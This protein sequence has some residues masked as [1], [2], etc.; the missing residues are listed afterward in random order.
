METIKLEQ[1]IESTDAEVTDRPCDLSVTI[2]GVSIDSRTTKPGDCFFAV[3]GENFDGHDFLGQAISNGACCAVVSK[4]VEGPAVPLLL[5]EDPVMAL[6]RLAKWYRGR[7]AAKVIA[8]TGSTGKTSTRQII[9]H[10]LKESCNCHQPIKNFNNAIGLPLT[11]L[12][13]DRSCEV[14]ITE[15]GT[16]HPGEIEYLTKIAQPDIALITNVAP[17]HIAGLGSIQNTIKEKCSIAI[18][19]RPNGKLIINGNQ[20]ELLDHCVANR[21]EFLTFGTTPGC[22][23]TATDLATTGPAGRLTI[24]DKEVTVPLAGMANLHNTLAAWAVCSQLQISILDFA[25]SIETAQPVNMRLNI[26]PLG[27]VTVIDDCYNASPTSM[28]NA[29]DCLG[30]IAAGTASRPVFICGSMAELGSQSQALHAQL[31][32]EIAR[33]CV[34]LLLAVGP[35]A[36]TIADSAMTGADKPLAAHVFE[37]TDTLCGKLHDFA[38][39]DDIILI[40]GSRNAKLELAIEKLKRLFA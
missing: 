17:A 18:G 22:D 39:S 16:N 21:I 25:S 31:G 29:L 30:R 2:T 26:L 27:R 40:K 36:K 10:V 28:A 35:F 19:L 5:V 33:S 15:L 20:K 37:N 1:L 38:A 13:T 24:A 9:H 23:V 32:E 4:P 34:K 12:S 11:I 8:I 7:I 14:L 3:G 6:G